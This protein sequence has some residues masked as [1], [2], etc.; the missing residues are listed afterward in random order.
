MVGL[1]GQTFS[2]SGTDGGWYCH[3]QDH[4]VRLQ[5]NLRVTAPLPDLFPDRQLITGVS[6]LHG[7][8]S[9]VIE[10]SHP[11]S[12][13]TPGCPNGV[14]PCLSDGGIRLLVDGKE[15]ESLLGPVRDEFVTDGI[16]LS[17]SNL[18]VECWQFGGDKIWARMY[19]EMM[20]QD[21]RHLL[22]EMDF[23]EWFLTFN[24]SA[25]PEWCAKYIYEHGLGEVQSRYA[26]FRVLTP[27]V[28][29]QLH[30]GV[31]HQDGGE[32]TWDGLVLPELELW[33]M[34]VGV[35]GLSLE[36]ESLTGLLGETSR[37]VL[38]ADGHEITKGSK[39]MRG[40]T[41]EYLWGST[42][43]SST[44]RRMATSKNQAR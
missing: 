9:L 35:A 16:S 42:S 36:D 5:V 22:A 18:P 37:P 27:T 23:E 13:S 6:I 20:Q 41:E 11:Y 25:A 33:Q 12:V 32:L 7:D 17:S 1:R 34:N 26:L 29:V 4:N 44:K 43:R 39:A 24:E 21:H 40:A 2:W 15:S 30:I 28:D 14:S 3:V 8:H 38:D 31:G 19:D 10:V